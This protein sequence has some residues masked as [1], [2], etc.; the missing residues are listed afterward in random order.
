MTLF[1]FF[2]HAPELVGGI[3]QHAVQ[4]A[5][6]GVFPIH[7]AAVGQTDHLLRQIDRALNVSIAGFHLAEVSGG[8]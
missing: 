6:A 5:A 1:L 2:G 8:N 3:A 7:I 4:D